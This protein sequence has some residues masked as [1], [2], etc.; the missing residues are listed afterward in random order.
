M[1]E[2]SSEKAIVSGFEVIRRS[3]IVLLVWGLAYLVFGMGPSLLFY[4]RAWPQ[5]SE[6]M[7]QKQPDPAAIQ[8]A[9]SGVTAYAPLMWVVGIVVMSVMYGAVFR[10]VLTPEDRRYAYLRLSSREVWLGLSILALMVVFVIGV[11]VLAVGIALLAQSLP[12]VVTFLAVLAT[13]FL[14]IWLALRLSLAAPMAWA[15]KRF[16]FADSWPLTAGHGL[17]L[18]GVGLA[19]VVIVL[20]M[21]LALILPIGLA[22]GLSGVLR[23]AS[24]GP[25]HALASLGPWL[26]VGCVVLGF[27]GALVYAVMGAPWAS[28]YQQLTGKAGV[29]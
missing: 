8:A 4:A 28:I 21:E 14:V 15:E 20:L 11:M 19:L 25:G 13:A 16:V 2:F 17:K 23:Q 26:V 3:P 12:G 9:M 18:F 27:F 22:V 7:A 1:A 24:A 10:A 5:L 6:A 29:A